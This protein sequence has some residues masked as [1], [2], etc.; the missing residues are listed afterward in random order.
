[1]FL[2]ADLWHF[3]GLSASNAFSLQIGQYGT[4]GVGTIMGMA[5]C[6]KYGRRTMWFVSMWGMLFALAGVAILAT[7]KTQTPNIV[8]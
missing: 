4:V 3:S 6:Q 2:N 5:L 8:W 7:L 1:M